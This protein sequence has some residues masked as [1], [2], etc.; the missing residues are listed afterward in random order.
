MLIFCYCL[1]DQNDDL[2]AFECA[3][4]IG[5]E[6]EGEEEEDE[7]EDVR[8]S[9]RGLPAASCFI[10]SPVSVSCSSSAFAILWSSGSCCL[11]IVFAS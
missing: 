7:A 4:E 3:S 9:E 10:C 11:R 2:E 1:S 8:G 5:D 6:E